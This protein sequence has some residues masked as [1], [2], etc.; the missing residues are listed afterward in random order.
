M[1]NLKSIFIGI[2]ITFIRMD[3]SKDENKGMILLLYCYIYRYSSKD[4]YYSNT[5]ECIAK[6]LGINFDKN[7]RHKTK[8]IK[9]LIK[10]FDFLRDNNIIELLQGNYNSLYYGFK[11]KINPDYYFQKNK[12]K[13]LSYASFDYLLSLEGRINK[14]NM[15]RVLFWVMDCST[16]NDKEQIIDA[17]SYSTAHMSEIL[18]IA[19]SSI[20][21]YLSKLCG[22]ENSDAPLLCFKNETLKINEEFRRFPNIYVKN[23]SFAK[24]N[25]ELQKNY[26]KTKFVLKKIPGAFQD[27]SDYEDLY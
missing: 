9:D 13:L 10:S 6:D 11:I 20:V 14:P 22:P 23:D 4:G 16:K 12:F 3:V 8:T 2:P 19:Q 26:I 27:I 21:K 24:E 17:C 1:V 18:G 15:F 7:N 5:I 25:V